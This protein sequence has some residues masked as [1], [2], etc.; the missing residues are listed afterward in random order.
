MKEEN[1][2]IQ[3]KTVVMLKYDKVLKFKLNKILHSNIININFLNRDKFNYLKPIS[4]NYYINQINL[5]IK[6][7]LYYK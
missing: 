5:P 6:L 1:S 7:V 3:N 2:A 4:I